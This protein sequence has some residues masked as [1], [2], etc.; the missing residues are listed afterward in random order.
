MGRQV[1]KS[2]HAILTSPSISEWLRT[3]ICLWEVLCHSTSNYYFWQQPINHH[4]LLVWGF[5]ENHVGNDIIRTYKS[6]WTK[7]LAINWDE[8]VDQRY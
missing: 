7:V 8:E 4:P 5:S 3:K 2:W 6:K 1:C